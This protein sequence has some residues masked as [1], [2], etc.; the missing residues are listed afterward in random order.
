MLRDPAPTFTV[1]CLP[2]CLLVAQK[3]FITRDPAH[4]KPGFC[5]GVGHPLGPGGR[6]A[7]LHLNC[8]Y[9]SMVLLLTRYAAS[10][11]P[12]FDLRREILQR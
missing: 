3:R 1:A 7:A 10:R 5:H 8:S 11:S 4:L 9:R 2:I 6:S 12:P